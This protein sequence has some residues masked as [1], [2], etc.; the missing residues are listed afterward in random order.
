METPRRIMAVILTHNAPE[1]L[2]RCLRAIAG[3][4]TPPESILV[5]DNASRPA[6]TLPPPDLC[7]IPTRVVRSDSNTGPAGGYA[8]ALGEFVASGY[9]HAWVLDDDMVPDPTCLEQLWAVAGRDPERAFVFP[10]SQQVDG[11][12]GVWP[13]WCGFVISRQIVEAV[14]LPIKELFWWAEDTEYLQW[15]IP[16]AGFTRLVANEA[17]VHHDAVRQGSGVPLWKYYYESRNMLYVHLYVKRRVGWYPRNI[18]RL[19]ARSVFRERSGRLRRLG[20]IA[21][22]LSDGARGRLGLRF[23]TEPMIE[24]PD[25]PAALSDGRRPADG[26]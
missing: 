2:A 14:G 25:G 7:P 1:S 13:S 3:Q 11:S 17:V 12:I 6:A 9:L 16:E 19:L 22:G 26:R 10:V 23:P 15:R 21:R 5:V 8:Q 20:V 18:T 4:T 24:D